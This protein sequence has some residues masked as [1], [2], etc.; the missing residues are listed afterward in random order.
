LEGCFELVL[1]LF[2]GHLVDVRIRQKHRQTVI[3]M[4]L[5]MLV[6]SLVGLFFVM[7]WQYYASVASQ[8]FGTELRN[9]LMKKINHLS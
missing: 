5:W 7:I 8:G 4:A 2:M 3:E 9:Q 6:M 1:P